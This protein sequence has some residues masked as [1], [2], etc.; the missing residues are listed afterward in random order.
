MSFKEIKPEEMKGNP[1]FLLNER[2]MLVTSENGDIYNM[3][4][5][6]WGGL[7]ILWSRKVNM[8][9]MRPSTLT[10]EFIENNDYYTVCFFDEKYLDLLRFIGHNSGRY[11][12]KMNLKGLTPVKQDGVVWYEEAKIV[13]VC[14]KM[15]ADNIRPENIIDEK[16]MD[17]VY[18]DGG[19]FH[20]VYYGEVIKCY[21][22]E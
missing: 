21:E 13:L 11:A 3:A 20:R 17:R 22:R 5:I 2:F 8:L 15:Y 18:P 19:N 16:I 14:K 9:F 1:F 6:N 12:N 7:G 10:S 4:T